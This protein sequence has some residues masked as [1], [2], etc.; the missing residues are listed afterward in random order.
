MK[1]V[2]LDGRLPRVANILFF[3]PE[4]ANG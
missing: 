1:I 4:I 3:Q 2:M